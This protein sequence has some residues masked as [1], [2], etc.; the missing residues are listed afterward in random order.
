MSLEGSVV[1]RYTLGRCLGR[2]STGVVHEARDGAAEVAL[3]LVPCVL[4]E[5]SIAAET[6]GAQLQQAFGRAHGLVPQVYEIGED[7]H[8]LYIAMELMTAPT[9]KQ[10]IASHVMSPEQ[11]VGFAHAICVVLEK[12][13]SFTPPELSYEAV[14]H[15]DL[16][17]EH[18]FVMADATVKLYDFGTAKG[19]EPRRPGTAVVGLTPQ[20]APPERFTERRARVGDD[21][22]AVGVMLYEMVA[23]HRPHS[24]KEDNTRRLQQA[25][26]LNEPREPLPPGCPLALAAIIDRLLKFQREHRYDTAAAIKS[27]LDAFLAGREPEALKTFNTVETIRTPR[28]PEPPPLPVAELKAEPA[29]ASWAAMPPPAPRRGA[30]RR[31]LWGGFVLLLVI[32]FLSEAVGCVMADRMRGELPQLNGDRVSKARQDYGR[33]L[34]WTPVGAGVRLLLD[35]P[36]R[37]RLI[38]VADEVIAGYR[39][40]VLTVFERQWR[41]CQEA[42]TWASQLG[43]RSASLEAKMLV[44]DAHLERIA[45]QTIAQKDQAAALRQYSAAAVKF[46]RAASLE[47]KSPDPY[48]G[49]GR[50]YLEPRGLN[51]VDR[52]VAAIQEAERRGHVIGWRQRADIGHAYRVRADGYRSEGEDAWERA[53]ADYERCVEFLTPIGD[54]ARNELR[55][56]RRYVRSLTEALEAKALELQQPVP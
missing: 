18:V 9:L 19:L 42:L 53:R 56:C 49:L 36:L 12:L 8:Y 23:G 6:R 46:E 31:V 5:E 30:G 35:Y 40:P 16:K 3:K 33:L 37:G 44:C 11:A 39:A 52:G 22:W 17:P 32:G 29:P 10:R 27:D 21:L 26:E 2:G 24:R 45:A 41:Q 34:G 25:I 1:G 13:H 14:M 51:D 48:L 15:A 54:R 47:T 20:Y 4:D 38:A 43:G 55:D 7:D 50:I 28:A